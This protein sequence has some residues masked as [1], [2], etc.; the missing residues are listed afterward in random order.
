VALLGELHFFMYI[1]VFFSVAPARGQPLDNQ[2]Q[3]ILLHQP[4]TIIIMMD[5]WVHNFI[6]KL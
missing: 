3:N 5:I 1:P 6:P 2:I 4:Q